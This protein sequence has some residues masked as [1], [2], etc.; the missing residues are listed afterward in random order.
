MSRRRSSLPVHVAAVSTAVAGLGML[1]GAL[2]EAFDG[3]PDMWV[4][5]ACGVPVF[6]AGVAVWRMTQVP[7]RVRILDVFV[8]VTLAWVVMA[9]IGA[10]PY[11]AT[12]RLPTVD[13]ALF[14]SI[15]GFTTTGAT[16]LSPVSDTSQGLLMYRSITQWIGG[17][18]VVVL[19]IAVLPTVGAGAMSL[20]Q[21]EAPGPAGE[22]LTPR[23]RQTARNLWLVYVGLSVV[24]LMAYLGAGMSLFDGFAHTFTTVSTGGF[25]PHDASLRHFDSAAVEWIAIAAMFVAGGS[26]A[27]YYRALR[28]GSRSLLRSTEFHVYAVVVVTAAVLMFST[29]AMGSTGEQQVREAL[30]TAI[31][32]ITTTGYTTADYGLWSEAAQMVILLALPFG[33][34]AGSTAGGIKFV[35]VIAI[36]SMAH[37]AALRQLHPGLVRP[38]RVGRGTMPEEVAGRVVGFMA[39]ATV[40]IGVGALVIALAGSDVTT[41]FSASLSSFANVGPGL[42]EISPSGDYLALSGP[43]RLVTMVQM[44]LGRLEI[45]PVILALSVVTLRRRRLSAA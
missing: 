45:F 18:G 37:R 22:R 7:A 27:L 16:V 28:G 21:A 1:A 32:I 34:M 36:A 40:I 14:E 24:V 42:G 13:Q 8:T 29:A 5:V 17:M 15:S 33:A 3:G 26:F 38:V 30:F 35:R 31:S 44:L 25:S 12:G 9:A 19:V 39:M 10:V 41:A 6:T 23:V 43:A 20:M 11:L 2:V 4:L